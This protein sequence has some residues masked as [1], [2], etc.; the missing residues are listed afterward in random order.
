MTYEYDYYPTKNVLFRINN[1]YSSF[2]CGNSA[3]FL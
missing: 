1:L 3:L 2:N